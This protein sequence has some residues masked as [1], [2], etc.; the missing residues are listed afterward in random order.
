MSGL[1]SRPGGARW[2]LPH[3][4]FFA[5][6]PGMSASEPIFVNAFVDIA[7]RPALIA[8]GE[9]LARCL[10]LA[11]NRP[12]PVRLQFLED[13]AALAGTDNA[14]V[15]VAS[16]LPELKRSGQSWPDIGTRWRAFFKSPQ[17]QAAVSTFLCTI[18][19]H[20]SSASYGSAAE[21]ALVMEKIRRLN[22]M[23]AEV[24]HDTGTNVIDF[25]RVFAHAGARALQTDYMLGGAAATDLAAHT[26]VSALLAVGLDDVLPLEIHERAR[27]IHEAD[28]QNALRTA[29]K[30]ARDLWLRPKP[31][32]IRPA[33]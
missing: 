14:T 6:N 12:W 25:D 17:A 13:E 10:E 4:E 22:L 21:A 20:V 32:R 11:A 8:A 26:I 23:A 16:L 19:R 18:F 5:H 3:W 7:E 27:E 28:A 1:G 15:L 24:S 9:Q 29:S 31:S 33:N 30:Y 2:R